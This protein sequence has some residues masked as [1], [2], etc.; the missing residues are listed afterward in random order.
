VNPPLFLAPLR[1]EVLAIRRAR[2]R[3]EVRRI[4]MGPVAATA[5]RARLTQE[6]DAGRPLVLFGF[7][8][9]LD[10]SVRAG[11]LVVARSVGGVDSDEKF[12]LPDADA[13]A[14]LLDSEGLRVSLGDLV[15]VPRVVRG[16]VEREKLAASGALACDMESLWMV[17]LVRRHPFVVVRAIVDTVGRDVIS[18][19]TPAAA[20]R[21]FSS[22]VRAARALALWAPT[23]V[24][25][26]PLVEAKE[27]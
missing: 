19:A 25:D 26:Y 7:A 20:T 14:K 22:L 5:A 16:G 11:D 1:I 21:A 6:I 9:A 18:F 27:S 23:A 17:P 8:G 15:S 10:P 13:V 12:A 3:P 24:V 4:G 2:P